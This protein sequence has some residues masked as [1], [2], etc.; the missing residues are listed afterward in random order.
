MVCRL[1]LLQASSNHKTQKAAEIKNMSS[2]YDLDRAVE[3]LIEKVKD[4]LSGRAASGLKPPDGGTATTAVAV[5]E[6]PVG[7]KVA[8]GVLSS[9]TWTVCALL[10]FLIL[11]TTF[12]WKGWVS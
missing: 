3:T 10:T 2:N 8:V 6:A 12:W 1:L 4:E 9:A 7:W 11:A 5:Y